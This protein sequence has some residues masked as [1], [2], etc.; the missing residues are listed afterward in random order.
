MLSYSQRE[1]RDALH[2]L[3]EHILE[4]DI[5]LQMTHLGSIQD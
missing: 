4:K 3:D 5:M 1:L 2:P